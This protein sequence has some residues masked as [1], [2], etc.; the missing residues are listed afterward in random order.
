MGPVLEVLHADDDDDD[1]DSDDDA[2]LFIGVPYLD[3]LQATMSFLVL[4]RYMRK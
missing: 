2:D 4:N 3:S 1:D